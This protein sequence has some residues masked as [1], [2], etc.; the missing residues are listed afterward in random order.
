MSETIFDIDE[1]EVGDNLLKAP[2]QEEREQVLDFVFYGKNKRNHLFLTFE[3]HHEF[4]SEMALDAF[5]KTLQALKL[6]LDDVAVLNLGALPSAPK[7]EEIISFFNPKTMVFLG[8]SSQSVGLDDIS[9]KTVVEH[10]GIRIFHTDTFDE[11]L[12]DGEKKRI[13][14]TT[15]KTLLA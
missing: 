11:M 14:W 12:A 13:F 1:G 10:G 7:K 15:I 8:T 4:M 5:T 3:A 9:A 6:T 2:T